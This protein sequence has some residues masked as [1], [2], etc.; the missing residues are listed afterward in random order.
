MNIRE[1]I[2]M[3][4]LSYVGQSE[5]GGDNEKY[6]DESFQKKLA[7]VGWK[8]GS[9]WCGYFQML[10]WKEAYTTGNAIVPKASQ[11]IQN[12]YNKAKTIPNPQ[13]SQSEN[14]SKNYKKWAS[15]T[16]DQKNLTYVKP[17]DLVIFKTG[18]GEIALNINRNNNKKITSIDSIGGNWDDKVSKHRVNLNDIEGFAMVITA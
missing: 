15:V 16:D 3:I 4:A 9:A 11:E 18:H 8:S 12:L 13:P 7:G 6:G 1:R 10:V 2:L 14:L 5:Y 17:G